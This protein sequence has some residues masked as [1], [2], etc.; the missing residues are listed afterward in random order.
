MRTAA[1]GA[2]VRRPV[3]VVSALRISTMFAG[4]RFCDSR[5]CS[6]GCHQSDIILKE[7][8]T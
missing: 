1:A 3:A 8:K 6:T 4:V 2:G 7:E 5:R